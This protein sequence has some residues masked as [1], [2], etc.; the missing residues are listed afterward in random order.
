MFVVVVI[1]E[2]PEVVL[3][4]N[5]LKKNDDLTKKS[6]IIFIYIY[7]NGQKIITFGWTEIEKHKFHKRKNPISIFNVDI[8]EILDKDSMDRY[9][10]YFIGY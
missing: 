2:L 4:I 6:R 5:L 9:F 10:K 7:K 8:N 3:K 1:T